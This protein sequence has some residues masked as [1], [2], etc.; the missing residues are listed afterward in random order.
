M[1]RR[2]P[3]LPVALL[4][5]GVPALASCGGDDDAAAP[6]GPG[7][8]VSLGETLDPSADAETLP[9][10]VAEATT[11]LRGAVRTFSD[12]LLTGDGELAYAFYTAECQTRVPRGTYLLI[13][14]RA[15]E[16]YGEPLPF[17]TYDATTSREDVDGE[18]TEVAAVDY[19][20]RGADG[21]VQS[22]E[23]WT[24]TDDGWR[25]SDC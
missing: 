9:P 10:D 17:A 19:T 14:T 12:A 22:D 1:S 13:V 20:F 4:L 15:G 11:E 2:A 8:E 7:D 21:L 5:L 25:L 18:P 3:A 23:E 16:V 6:E 24:L